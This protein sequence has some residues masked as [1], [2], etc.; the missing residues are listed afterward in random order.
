MN[1]DRNHFYIK[2][3]ILYVFSFFTDIRPVIQSEGEALSP[4]SS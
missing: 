3:H 4:M 2:S 1:F